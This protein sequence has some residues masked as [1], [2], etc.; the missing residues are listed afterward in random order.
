MRINILKLILS[1]IYT[2]EIALC[3]FLGFGVAELCIMY[4]AF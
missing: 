1:R 3:L 4:G 2:D